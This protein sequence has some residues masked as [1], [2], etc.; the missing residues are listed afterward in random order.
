ML[1]D[2][3][4]LFKRLSVTNISTRLFKC[5]SVAGRRSS[6]LVL[7]P[8]L[9]DNERHTLRLKQRTHPHNKTGTG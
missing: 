8:S 7:S 5:P 2:V 3:G 4:K 9:M 1:I 6:R